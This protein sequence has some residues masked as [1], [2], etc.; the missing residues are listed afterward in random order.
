MAARSSSDLTPANTSSEGERDFVAHPD[1]SGTPQ[2]ISEWTGRDDFPRCALGV[3]VDIRGFTGVVIEIMGR[4]F[5]VQS[6]DGVR[7]RFNGDRLKA[8]FAPRDRTKPKNLTPRA[9]PKPTPKAPPRH[10]VAEV[11]VRVFVAEPDFA[12]PVEAIG[13]YAAQSDFPKCAYGKHVEIP[14]FT[15]VVVE[16]VKDSVRV[17]S[18]AGS[19]RRFNGAA[20]KRLYWQA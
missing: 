11:P 5:R 6:E 17:Q 9:M 18:E 15:G 12:Q 16:I 4:S 10:L 14:G 3:L 2:L 19:I 20:L 7:Q 1:F 8:L 13:V